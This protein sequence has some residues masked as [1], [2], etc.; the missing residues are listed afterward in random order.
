MNF[1]A[2][3]QAE[4]AWDESKMVS[5]HNWSRIIGWGYKAAVE[6]SSRGSE[7]LV[8]IPSTTNKI[9]NK[10][11]KATIAR[12]PTDWNSI[13][14]EQTLMT[15]LS[16]PWLSLIL[17]TLPHPLWSSLPPT[18]PNLPPSPTLTV[19]FSL[20]PLLSSFPFFPCPLHSSFLLSFIWKKKL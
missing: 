8:L 1:H 15:N 2:I 12:Y 6:H 3:L 19:S 5:T 17:L 13:V 10:E 14:R 9:S 4:A 16:A 18:H 20:T 7:V 11:S